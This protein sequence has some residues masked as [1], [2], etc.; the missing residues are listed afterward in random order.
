MS[1]FEIV[2]HRGAPVEVPENTLPAFQR[3]IAL[4]A[5]AIELDVRLTKDQEPVVFHYFYL[6]ELTDLPGPVFQFTRQELSRARFGP[7]F[8]QDGAGFSVPTLREVLET[9][10]GQVA[11]EIE[12]KG[13]EPEAPGIIGSLLQE[14]RS[15]WDGFE[16]TSFEPQLLVA[17]RQECP[18]IAV[19]LLFPRSEPWMGLDVV[20]HAAL[21]RARLA[22]ARAVHLHPSQL[23]SQVIKTIRQAGI[24]IHAWDVND[25]QA[26][27]L[28]VEYGIPRLCTDRLPEALAYRARAASAA[29]ECITLHGHKKP[30][31]RDRLRLRA[32]AYAIVVHD[33]KVLLM[34]MRHTGKYHLPGGEV[35]PGERLED[36]LTRELREETGVEVEVERLARFQEFFFYYDLSGKAYHGLQFYYVCRPQT[37]SLLD[38]AEVDDDAAGAP[39]WVDIGTLHA[40]DFQAH[41]DLVLQLCRELAA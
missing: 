12:I 26:L 23:S 36:G 41:G 8:K 14:Y 39:R 29:V 1:L 15:L 11:L 10:G 30:V 40:G 3:A 20:A 22:G 2:A 25:D 28:V 4:G 34:T 37:L 9:I 13:P 19:D 21:H 31:P 32:A 5:D 18:G 35:D 16:I 7:Q 6:Q 27:D 38:D 24:E 17:M 33:G